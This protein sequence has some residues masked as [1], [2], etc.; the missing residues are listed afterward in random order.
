[1]SHPHILYFAQI[2]LFDAKGEGR[3]FKINKLGNIRGVWDY[4][5]VLFVITA[6][7]FLPVK[8]AGLESIMLHCF[9]LIFS[10]ASDRTSQTAHSTFLFLDSLL[11]P[12]LQLVLHGEDCLSC[13][14]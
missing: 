6:I 11:F 3:L 10:L 4:R 9:I 2:K 5:F 1:M 13:Y 12:R 8:A 7:N 14:F